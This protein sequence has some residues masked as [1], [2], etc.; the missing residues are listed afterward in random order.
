M[1][2]VAI[3]LPRAA[4]GSR[5]TSFLLFATFFCITF[6][7]VHWNLAGQL[8]IADVLTVLFLVAFALTFRGPMPRTAVVVLAFFAAFALVYLFGF[9]NLDSRQ[10]VD[11]FSKGMVKF[12][13]HFLFLAASV[14]YLVQRGRAFYR[15]T[16]VWFTLGLAANCVYAVLQLLSA[17]A[18]HNLD[19]TVLS[20]LTG[21][22]SSINIYGSVGGSSVY[23][24]NSLTGDPNHLGIMLVVPLL[25][26]LPVYLRSSRSRLKTWLAVLLGFMLIVMLSTLSRSAA[27]GLGVGLCV[28]VLPYRRF[29]RSR[30]LLVPLAG[31][32]IVLAYILYR[33]WHYFSVVLRSRVQTGGASSSAHFAV[34]DFIPKI[35]HSHPLLGL[36]LNTFSVYYE[37]VT[38]KANWGPHSYWVA[39]IVETGLVG[40][41]LF[42][43]F[44]R[45]V[46]VR[47]RA[48]R[49]LGRL[50]DKARDPDGAFVRPLAWG[51]TAALTG[52]LAANFFYLTMQFYYFYAFLS[53][54]LALP[55]VFG[56]QRKNPSAVPSVG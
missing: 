14:T 51:M 27:L 30:A 26:L 43:V 22:A 1:S 52:T 24:P 31:V 42:I 34:Y 15:R 20:P 41:L 53:L 16:L 48:A 56:R 39:L 8:G 10:S 33:R 13:L 17:R 36:G 5:V 19:K 35:V 9:F 4:A 49:A 23:R 12:V 44:L 2:S 38:G 21:G 32:A 11:Q 50:L 40:L 45:Y 25:T 18:G 46:Y 29:L 47:L 37:F 28:L 7:K 54:V 55:V 6:E 3:A